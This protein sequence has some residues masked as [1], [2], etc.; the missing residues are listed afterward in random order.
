MNALLLLRT[1]PALELALVPSWNPWYPAHQL[2]PSEMRPRQARPWSPPVTDAVDAPGPGQRLDLQQVPSPAQLQQPPAADQPAPAPP[3]PA[4]PAPAQPAPAQPAPAQPAPGQAA[5]AQPGPAEPGPAAPPA[6]D[7]AAAAAPAEAPMDAAPAATPPA[8]VPTDE[9]PPAEPELEPAPE[10]GALPAT[11]YESEEMD[12]VTVTIDRRERDIQDVPAS[13]E[14]FSQADLDRKGIT[15]MRELTA[16]TPHVEIGQQEGNT[17]V[18][19]RGIGNTNNTE[20]GDPA[21]AVH[22]DGV[23]IP[24]PRGLNT[25]FFDVER[26]EILRGPQGTLRGRNAMA[27]TMNV[28]SAAP[29]LGEWEADATYQMGNYNQRLMKAMVNVPL[30]ERFALRIATF[31]ERRDP[32]FENEGGDPEIRASEDADTWAYRISA[33]YAPWDNVKFTLRHDNTHERGTGVIGTNVTEPLE[34]GIQPEEIPD[35]RSLRFVGH[36]PSQALDHWGV[37]LA[38]E[39]DFGPVLAELTSSYRDLEYK[40]TT[41]TTDGVNYHGKPNDTDLD[42]YSSTYWHT[43]SESYVNELR[44][45]APDTSSFRWTTGFFH[46]YETQYVLL[47]ENVDK[48]WGW[49]GQ[50]F[51][52]PDVTM[53]SYAGYADGTLDLLDSLRALG[54]IRVTREYKRRNGMA[55][56]YSWSCSPDAPDCVFDQHRFGTEGFRFAGEDRTVYEPSGDPIADF[57]NGISSYGERD[58]LD[59]FL[60]QDGATISPITEQ[61]GHVRYTFFDFRVGGEYDLSPDQMLY[62]TFSTGHKAGGFNDTL[63]DAEGN[64]IVPTFDPEVVYATEVGSK[65]VLLDDRLTLNAAAFWY[66]Y[67]NYQSNTV[68]T[69]GNVE[70]DMGFSTSVRRNTGNARVLG[71][72]AEAVGRLPYGFTANLA[73]IFLDARYLGAS[74]ADT[75]VSWD[76]NQLKNVSIKGHYLPRAPRFTLAYGIAQGIPTEVGTFD[77]AFSGQTKTK[78]YMTHFNGEGYDSDGN[79]N[80]IFS[81]VVPGY[82]RLDASAGYTRPAGDI[83]FEAFVANLMSTTYMTSIIN[84]PGLNLRFYNPPRQFGV[85]LQLFL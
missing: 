56:P 3:A 71:V 47:V 53:M 38:A 29:R 57:E 18:F 68:E 2:W 77:W 14:S 80:P 72:E 4:Q 70:E 28:I 15:S 26:V 37:S 7:A 10:A 16:A 36:Q 46:L 43:T 79:V 5:P 52:H 25:M 81:D 9:V 27:G 85:R 60:A 63:T 17:E 61:H 19:I 51:N 67:E 69:L 42:L 35:V 84:V 58:T 1:A 73:A 22:F 40:Q 49:A 54:G 78:Q 50:E 6:P 23:Y 83:R 21:A 34:A 41:G 24:R 44:L 75:R 55:L 45:F 82:T 8:D 65:N 48:N 30:G 39:F 59:D 66:A 33:A 12:T 32:F 11:P 13:V 20:I 62:A 74:V 76:A 64:T 31:S